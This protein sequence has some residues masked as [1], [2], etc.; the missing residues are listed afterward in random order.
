MKTIRPLHFIT[1]A[2]ILFGFGTACTNKSQI[3]LKTKSTTAQSL[4]AGVTSQTQAQI[5]QYQKIITQLS[6][7]DMTKMSAKELVDLNGKISGY[8]VEIE[9]LKAKIKDRAEEQIRIAIENNA[10]EIMR[11]NELNE[12]ETAKA[13]KEMSPK[14]NDSKRRHAARTKNQTAINMSNDKLSKTKA[15]INAGKD[16][17]LSSLNAVADSLKELNQS[18]VYNG[19]V[20]ELRSLYDTAEEVTLGEAAVSVDEIIEYLKQL[21]KIKKVAN[22][23]LSEHREAEV[24]NSIDF[25]KSSF[26]SSKRKMVHDIEMKKAD[27]KR[28]IKEMKRI[29]RNHKISFQSE[30]DSFVRGVKN[31][32]T[33]RLG[34]AEGSTT[35]EQ[36]KHALVLKAH[37]MYVSFD[38]DQ[39]QDPKVISSYRRLGSIT[40]DLEKKMKADSID[41]T[42]ANEVVKAELL[43]SIQSAMDK[44]EKALDAAKSTSN[45]WKS[46]RPKEKEQPNISVLRL[47]LRLSLIELKGVL[48]HYETEIREQLIRDLVKALQKLIEK[49][50]SQS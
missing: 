28:K 21:K 11:I 24:L 47:N 32:E 34:R 27:D 40:A 45:A 8:M 12:K 6:A 41:F 26:K 17:T 48:S 20:L 37:L 39:I 14:M 16:S 23:E 31:L 22:S 33:V 5:S 7:E 29:G 49:G 43:K 42:P 44:A 3:G 50:N 4:F 30:M 35:L 36:K 38:E 10:A 18:V 1:V 2:T 15:A 9:A 46:A 13:R 19:L 25:L